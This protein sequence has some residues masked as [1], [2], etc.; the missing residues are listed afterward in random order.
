MLDA[1]ATRGSTRELGGEYVRALRTKLG[2]SLMKLGNK[3]GKDKATIYRWE[4]AGIDELTWLGVLAKLDLAG[5][6]PTAKQ[7]DAA[8]REL[9]AKRDDA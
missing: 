5:W 3:L 2:D 7:L 1:V 9:A 8:R 4:D 6:Q